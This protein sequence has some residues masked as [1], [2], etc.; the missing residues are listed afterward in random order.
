MNLITDAFS[1]GYRGNGKS[2]LITGA[3]L[4]IVTGFATLAPLLGLIAYVFLTGYFCAIYFHI[5]ESTAVGDT[6]A[7]S[8]P[9]ITHITE[10]LIMP[11]IKVVT[12]FLFSYTPFLAYVISQG[13]MN[14]LTANLLYILGSTYFP[15]ALLASV[16]LN[17]I[18]VISP[19]IVIPSIIKAGAKYW[20]AVLLLYLLYLLASLI[21]ESLSGFSIAGIILTGFLSMYVLMTNGRLLGLVYRDCAEELE[22]L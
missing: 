20:M 11:L 9:E 17:R 13:D 3:I 18:S 16:V 5:I 1:Y 7:P 19:H 22:W 2:M 8:A 15:M 4:S 12:V 14:D 6:D 21:E 10:D